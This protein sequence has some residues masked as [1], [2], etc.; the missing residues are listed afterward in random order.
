VKINNINIKL[1]LPPLIGLLLIVMLIQNYWTPLQLEKA[2]NEF[3][4][5]TREL[6]IL[7]ETAISRHLLQRDFGALFSNLEHLEKSYEDHWL[8]IKLY[9]DNGKQIYPV[10]QR[11]MNA[12]DRDKEL[13]H[14]I[15]RIEI[16]GTYLG[17][18]ELDLDWGNQKLSVI[19]NANG[20]RDVVVLMVILGILVTVISQYRIVYRPLKLLD[21]ATNKISQG[22]FNIELP[23]T[24]EDE[25]GRLTKSFHTMAVELA[26]QKNALDEHAIVSSTDQNGEIIYANKK[27][28]EISRFSREELIGKTHRVIKSNIHPPEFYEEMWN[29]IASGDVWHGEICNQSKIGETYWVSSTIVPFLDE[30]GVPQRYISIR[31]DITERKQAEEQLQYMANHDILTGLPTRRLGKENISSAIAA[32][33]R[34]K[35]KAAV[36]FIDLDGFKAVNDTLG[37]DGG[38]LLLVDVAERLSN[39][40]RE[41]DSVARIGGDEFM[42]VMSGINSRENTANV[43]Q[44]LI[45]ALVLPFT[46]GEKV[47]TIGASIGIA[48]YPD[49]GNE[50]EVLLKRADEVMYIVKNKGKNNFA[51]CDDV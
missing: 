28:L 4:N 51:L 34:D 50:P 6:L 20:I 26:F 38:D 48:L 10:F 36:F 27:F 21:R 7:T 32:A 30:Q 5:H 45:D 49:H 40:L 2:K 35:N 39:C 19:E 14:V 24:V 3:E 42:I 11:K 16:E 23:V 18:F 25:I 37:H 31:T 15:H 33:R 1:A 13:I 29:T 44:K 41:I 46:L 12:V 43:A 17:Q 22:D 47:V 9:N 8:N